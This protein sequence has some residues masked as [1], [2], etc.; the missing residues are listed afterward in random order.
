MFKY[1]TFQY[2]I[3]YLQ[4]SG[5]LSTDRVCAS[6]QYIYIYVI[7]NMYMYVYVYYKWFDIKGV[8]RGQFLHKFD[9][10]RFKKYSFVLVCQLVSR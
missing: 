5:I 9:P 1:D 3:T 8:T 4:F 6:I 2:W 10:L 7:C